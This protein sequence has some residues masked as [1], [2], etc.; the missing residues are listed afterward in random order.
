MYWAREG[1]D[2]AIPPLAEST[3][4]ALCI[5]E[6]PMGNPQG[7]SVTTTRFERPRLANALTN[8]KAACLYPN[9]A[10]MF[11]EAKE[12]GFDNAIVCDAL[13][14]VA[15]TASANIFMARG[16]EVF[17]P[18]P[19]GTFLNGITRQRVITLLRGAGIKVHETVLSL[20]D[21][22]NSDEM[23]A[24]GNYSKV[25]P[26]VRFDDHEP[27]PGPLAARARELYF[28]WAQQSAL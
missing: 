20:D 15:E 26:I 5:E 7:F 2:Y 19:N 8:A 25:V 23:F 22:A 16:G 11:R 12:K 10:R 28:E 3:A 4:F 17:T 1:G 6:R 13:G 27:G 21:F 18:V 24:T 9:N 14:N